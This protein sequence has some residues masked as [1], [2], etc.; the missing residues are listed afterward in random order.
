MVGYLTEVRNKSPL[1]YNI[2]GEVSA[3][4]I[5][6]G[7][8]AIGAS[9]SVSSNP[10]EAK[11]MANHADAVVLNTGSLSEDRAEAMLLAG[12]VANE[13]GIPVILDPVAV[14]ATSFRTSV[15]NEILTTIKIAA[16]CGN[17][18]EI[19]V[20]GGASEKTISPD[21][22]LSEN[23]PSIVRKVANKYESIVIATSKTDIVTDGKKVTYCQ[24]GDVMLQNITAS[25]C[26]LTSIIG[27]FTSIAGDN[28]YEAIVEAVSAY[29]IAGERAKRIAKGPG[30]FI[31]N[32]LDELYLLKSETIK[33]QS[34]LKERSSFI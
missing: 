31:P 17:T 6:N 5:A 33:L 10:K 26:L 14:G 27:A 8:I 11:E 28:Q 15:I 9:P 16:I 12:K 2:T 19:S 1:I 3:H 29:G 25:G 34:H 4:F 20:L 7:L 30:T 24:N 23:N 21:N 22:I 18:G 13:K 32:F